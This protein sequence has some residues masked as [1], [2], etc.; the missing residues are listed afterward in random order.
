MNFEISRI[1]E[2][3]IDSIYSMGC[4]VA[5]FSADGGKNC[6]WPKETLLRLVRSVGDVCLKIEVNERIVGFCL[7]MIHQ[8]TKKAVIENFYLVKE[9]RYLENE[10]FNE[11]EKEIVESGAEFMAY[12]FDEEDDTNELELFER[13]EFF[14]GHSHKWM[15]KNIKFNNPKQN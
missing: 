9:Y 7:V 11:M 5:D 14:E 12:L 3:D 4:R 13:H 8:A 1:V 6:F 15:H 2:A 10:L